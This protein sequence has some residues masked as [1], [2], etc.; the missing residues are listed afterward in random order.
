MFRA[1]TAMIRN[2]NSRKIRERERGGL[3]AI[4]NFRLSSGCIP[5]DVWSFL[6]NVPVLPFRTLRFFV[7][8]RQIASDLTSRNDSYEQ[9]VVRVRRLWWSAANKTAA[10]RNCRAF[11]N[12]FPGHKNVTI[13]ILN[14]IT[15]HPPKLPR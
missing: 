4:A 6:E 1:N 7:S 8:S 12:V 9:L 2:Y 10:C 15:L 14:V 13:L 11:A 3:P 5:G